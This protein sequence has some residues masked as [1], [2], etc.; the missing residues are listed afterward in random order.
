MESRGARLFVMGILI[1][2][3]AAVLAAG[4]AKAI[5]GWRTPAAQNHN[6]VLVPVQAFQQLPGQTPGPSPKEFIPIPRNDNGQGPGEPPTVPGTGS[7]QDCDRILYFYQGRLYQL[8]PGPMPRNGGNP[9]FFY[10]QPYEGPQIPGFPGP[11]MP[12]SPTPEQPLP[13]TLKF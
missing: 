13:P 5:A 3:L 9:E 6:L 12:G 1:G 8:R 2:G 4:G 7:P 11:M 10:M